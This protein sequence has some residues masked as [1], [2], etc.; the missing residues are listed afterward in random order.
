MNQIELI[1]IMKL[2]NREMH[3]RRNSRL[4]NFPGSLKHVETS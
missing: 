1:L 3:C 2:Q 4:K